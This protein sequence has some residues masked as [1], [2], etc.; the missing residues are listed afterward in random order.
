M[1]K[2]HAGAAALVVA[3]LALAAGTAA[4]A[5]DQA[6]REPGIRLGTFDSRAIAA[7]YY[8]SELFSGHVGELRERH[9]AAKAAGDEELVQALDEQGEGMQALAHRQTFCAAPVP[10]IIER[11]EEGE[12]A[13]I[14][15][16]AGVDAIV[17]KWDLVYR[18]SSAHFVDVTG[19]LA[20]HFD[21]DENTLKVI[22]QVLETEPLPLEALRDH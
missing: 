13:R 2:R 19:A 3:F 21:P 9:E 7:A 11:L 12:L 8:R 6:Q 20:Q 18:R 15:E 4:Q 1:N 16:Q 14:A 10:E 17:S 5:P 22:Q